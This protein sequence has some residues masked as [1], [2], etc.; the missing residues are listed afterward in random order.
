MWFVFCGMICMFPNKTDILILK[1]ACHYHGMLMRMYQK[2]TEIN[3]LRT[4]NA[5]TLKAFKFL[6]RDFD[7]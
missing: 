6:L 4:V 1:R 3:Y 2:K 7:E 5:V